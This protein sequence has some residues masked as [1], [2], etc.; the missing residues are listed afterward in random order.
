MNFEGKFF[1]PTTVREAVTH[2]RNIVTI[3]VLDKIGVKYAAQ[4]AK[5]RFGIVSPLEENL[6]LALGA[7]PV[8]LYEM[9]TAYA[10]LANGGARP[11]PVYIKSVEDSDGYTLEETAP[12]SIQIIPPAIAYQMV[13]IMTNVVRH[14]TAVKVHQ[15]ISHPI[16]G[17]TGTTNNYIDAWFI[18]FTPDIVTGVWVGKDDNTPLGRLETGSRSA[19]PIWID[20]MAPTLEGTPAYDFTPPSDVVFVK[21]DKDTGLLTRGS[22]EDALYEGFV[23]G[24]EP[25]RFSSPSSG[26]SQPADPM[27]DML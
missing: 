24:T 12:D 18:G 4:Y 11:K 9:V 17:K 13:N 15:A 23:D 25:T 5:E 20:F 8:S 21:I 1:G 16:A 14:G 22:G 3:K 10:T 26:P 27:G 19:V 6:S 2:S 7:S